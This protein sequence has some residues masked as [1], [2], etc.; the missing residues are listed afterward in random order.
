MI[1][2]TFDQQAILLEP[3]TLKMNSPLELSQY[4]IQKWQL[5][6]FNPG[7]QFRQNIN[8]QKK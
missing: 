6:Y 3:D 8:E 2:K 7:T 1:L 4:Q 5:V